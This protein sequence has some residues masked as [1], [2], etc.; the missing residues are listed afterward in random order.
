[1]NK[2]ALMGAAGFVAPRHMR[3]IKD[4]GCDLVAAVDPFDSVGV[5]DTYFPRASFF[6]EVERFDRHIDKLKRTGNPVDFFSICTPNYL[7]DSHIRLALRNNCNAICEKPLV[8]KPKNLKNLEAIENEYGKKIYSI[9]Q[10]RHHPV[11]IQIK[12]DYKDKKEKVD[13]KLKYVT[14]RGKWYHHSWKGDHAKSG[15]LPL[16]IGVHFFDMLTWV[17]G[18]PISNEVDVNTK[19]TVSGL[20]R[21]DR[22]N[23][24]WFLS[25]DDAN[26]PDGVSTPSYRSILM[27]N[28]ELEFSKGFKDLHTV[29]YREIL[30]GRGFGIDDVRPSLSIVH[31]IVGDCDE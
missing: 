13:V 25:I 18:D 6:T 30:E 29:S 16:N 31:D 21:L 22:A 12:D 20:L 9:L 5:I 14:S 10:L 28:K 4:N 24:E 23:I 17:F 2:F 7:H 1:M 3:A 27:N 19:D 26:I 8:I 11:I 15:G